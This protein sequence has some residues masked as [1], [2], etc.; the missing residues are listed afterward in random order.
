MKNLIII[1]FLLLGLQ[2]ATSIYAYAPASQCINV[3]GSVFLENNEK[4]SSISDE[5]KPEP[6]A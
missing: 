5:M 1:I 3:R 4:G 6:D 2:S